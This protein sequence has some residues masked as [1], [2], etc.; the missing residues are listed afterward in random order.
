MNIKELRK[1]L[2]KVDKSFSKCSDN[3]VFEFNRIFNKIADIAINYSEKKIS[4]KYCK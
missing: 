1:D 4:S 3:E 2:I